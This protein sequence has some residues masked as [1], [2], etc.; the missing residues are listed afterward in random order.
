MAVCGL[1]GRQF[2]GRDC[3]GKVYDDQWVRCLVVFV[4]FVVL[5]VFVVG[6]VG[7]VE[8]VERRSNGHGFVP[9]IR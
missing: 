1:F 7:D 2:P 8:V 5:V 4:V 6:D 3:H 9:C